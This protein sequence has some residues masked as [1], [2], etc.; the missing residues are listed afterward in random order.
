[1]PSEMYFLRTLKAAEADW[2]ISSGAEISFHSLF[3]VTFRRGNNLV[4]S[5]ILL[6]HL[7]M[8]QAL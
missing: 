4:D 1:M 7:N 2:P 8:K 3:D 5:L 6:L